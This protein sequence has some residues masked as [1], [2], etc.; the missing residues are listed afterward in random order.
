MTK[1]LVTK[2]V[3][4]HYSKYGEIGYY[5]DMAQ[6]WVTL[7]DELKQTRKLAVANGKEVCMQRNELT[8]YQKGIMEAVE[9]VTK[10][11]NSY[12][13]SVF[14]EPDLKKASEILGKNGMTLDAI[15]ASVLRMATADFINRIQKH[16][17][18]T[19]NGSDMTK[20]SEG[21]DELL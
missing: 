15:S 11:A 17:P 14:P 19:N 13:L 6:D 20:E 18:E 3:A 1:L 12:P 8:R 7:Y 2:D 4:K 16:F 21:I 9:D 5:R 10:W